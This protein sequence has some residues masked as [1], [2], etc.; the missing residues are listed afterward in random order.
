MPP[1]RKTKRRKSD[2][3][4]PQSLPPFTFM[5]TSTVSAPEASA[6]METGAAMKYDDE[7]A[8]FALLSYAALEG[9]ANVLKFGAKKY[10]PDNWRKG[11][12]YR[13]LISAAMRHLMAFSDGADFD[14]ES[15]LPHLDHAACMI[16]FLQETWRTRPGLDDRYKDRRSY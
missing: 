14:P 6:K 9:T 1:K 16:M 3:P 12:M 11:F 8:P 7:K 5:E 2:A 4:G 13:R 15:G 10:A